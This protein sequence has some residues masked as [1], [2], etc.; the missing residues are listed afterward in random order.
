MDLIELANRR[1]LK[2]LD[3]DDTDYDQNSAR[4]S[5][6]M[7]GLCGPAKRFGMPCEA[8]VAS[9]ADTNATGEPMDTSI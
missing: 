2:P 8:E 6:A 4:N 1:H 5:R 9:R 7:V 3:A